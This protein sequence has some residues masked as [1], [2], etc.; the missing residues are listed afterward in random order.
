MERRVTDTLYPRQALGY[1]TL[2]DSTAFVP[3]VEVIMQEVIC[4][5]CGTHAQ[6]Q[7]TGSEK[8]GALPS[9]SQSHT[10]FV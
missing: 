10:I 8:E 1:S 4:P 3:E 2:K 7:I 9:Y 5:P 6:L